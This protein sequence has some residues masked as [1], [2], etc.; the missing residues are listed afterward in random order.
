MTRLIVAAAV[1]ASLATTSAFAQAGV[2]VTVGQ[3]K[4]L[5]LARRVAKIDVEN[6]A[7]VEAKTIT[8]HAGVSLIGK[9]AGRTKVRF[10]TVDGTEYEFVLFVTSKGAK[11]DLP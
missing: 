2:A 8:R 3:T 1:V 10:A 5:T 4:T 9:A 6:P 7:V 11:V